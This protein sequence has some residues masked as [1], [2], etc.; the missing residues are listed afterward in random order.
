VSPDDGRDLKHNAV[1]VPVFSPYSMATH[2]PTAPSHTPGPWHIDRLS[3]YSPICIKPYPG[4]IV[5]DIDG[6]D[7][8]AEANA[9]LIAAAPELLLAVRSH[10]A[11]FEERIGGLEE[12]HDE[13][14]EE[15]ADQDNIV[16]YRALVA[17]CDRVLALAGSPS[18]A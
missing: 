8:E 13:L 15:F 6:T 1:L 7:P 3:D 4:R 9:A 12:E 16:H 14:G 17:E 10:R 11:A 2:E 5:C 18:L